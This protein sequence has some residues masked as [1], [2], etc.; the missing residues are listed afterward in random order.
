MS[1]SSLTFAGSSDYLAY[2]SYFSTC[3]FTLTISV[4][5]MASFLKPYERTLASF[6]LFSY[7]FL[8]SLNLHR[9]EEGWA[10][11]ASFSLRRW[12]GWF[13]L[14]SVLFHICSKAV[15]CS[16]YS[17]LHQS[18]SFNF[19]QELLLCIHEMV[20]NAWLSAYLGLP[21]LLNHF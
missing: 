7:H 11:L 3:C 6:R 16:C 2:S 5:E 17:C 21:S 20:Q 13:D 12:C 1:P 4:L 15:S 10:L 19:I 18:T 8:S 14:H 9:I